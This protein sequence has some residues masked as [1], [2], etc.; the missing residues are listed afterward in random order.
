MPY[1]PTLPANNSALSSAQMRAQLQGLKALIDAVPNPGGDVTGP[2]GASDGA[3]A[4]FDGATGKAIKAGSL[5]A[6]VN[7]LLNALPDSD[8]R[9]GT[10]WWSNNGVATKSIP[11]TQQIYRFT[12]V[13][14]GGS[15]YQQGDVMAPANGEPVGGQPDIHITSVDENGAVTGFD[16]GSG[17]TPYA[18][19]YE[20]APPDGSTTGG[21]GSGFAAT[22]A[23]GA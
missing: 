5:G 23:T 12:G 21:S 13:A 10:S 20:D 14:S 18:L 19:Y 9:D 16:N 11:R 17:G 15:G 3:V 2:A 22:L 7:A 6:L 8:P 1:D 4:V